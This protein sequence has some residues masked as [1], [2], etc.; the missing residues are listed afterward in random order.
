MDDAAAPPP[1]NEKTGAAH[2]FESRFWK[3]LKA[4][5]YIRMSS[6]LA[7]L[8]VATFAIVLNVPRQQ[9]RHLWWILPATVIFGAFF[10]LKTGYADNCMQYGGCGTYA[11]TTSIV[12]A[13]LFAL[14]L[15][16]VLMAIANVRKN[17]VVL[18]AGFIHPDDLNMLRV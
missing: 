6:V 14:V 2:P 12:G 8:I 9:R 5:T 1:A 17:K 13:I 4:H 11:L 15:A 10:T 3:N 18:Y 7:A 16:A